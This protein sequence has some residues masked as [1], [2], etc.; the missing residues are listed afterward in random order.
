MRPTSRTPTSPITN[1][2]SRAARPTACRCRAQSKPCV[3]SER[4]DAL[5]IASPTRVRG[6][7]EDTE[8][9]AKL[10]AHGKKPMPQD[11]AEEYMQADKGRKIGNLKKRATKH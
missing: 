5:R 7:V 1:R 9:R 10:R 2:C 11:V 8:G 6:H 4:C 3:P